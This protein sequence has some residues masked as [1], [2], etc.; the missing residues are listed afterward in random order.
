MKDGTKAL[1]RICNKTFSRMDNAKVH[2]KKTH[3]EQQ[4]MNCP[5]CQQ[6]YPSKPTLDQHVTK[7]H[8]ITLAELKTSKFI[9]L[10][11]DGQSGLTVL[12][13]GKV[14]CSVCSVAFS[15][16][17]NGTVHFKKKHFISE[18]SINYEVNDDGNI[19]NGD[20][21]SVNPEKF[22]TNQEFVPKVEMPEVGEPMMK[23]DSGNN[24]F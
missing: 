10:T 16:R 13:N 19:L 4:P 2:F 14:I 3:M 17:D 7:G 24:D 1:C 15:R 21:G 8:K 22:E 11:E 18:Q 20:S 23:S 12:E 6:E 5:I 9:G